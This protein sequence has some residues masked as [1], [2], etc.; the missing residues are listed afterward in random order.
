LSSEGVTSLFIDA[1]N[2]LWI[3]T[4]SGLNVKAPN[5]TTFKRFMND[6]QDASSISDNYILC[7]F[8]DSHGRIWIG[9][10]GHGLN[11][12]SKNWE[13]FMHIGTA[14]GL[15][16]NSIYGI[17][18]DK[19]GYL[20]I[21]TENGLTKLNPADF[22]VQNYNR[23]D[24]LVCKEFNANSY[25]QDTFGNLYF[26]GYNGVVVFN[27]E[28]ISKN[29]TVP[30]LSFVNLRLFNDDVA[31]NQNGGILKQD[32]NYTND[33]TFEYDQNVFA[34]EFAVLNYINSSKNKF[35]YKLIG[36]E[37]QWNISDKPVA[38]YMNLSPGTYTLQVKGSNNDGLWNETPISLKLNILPPLWKTWW[39]YS[40][41][42][43]I[44]LGLLYAWAR[45]S[46]RRMKLE[47]DLELEHLESKKQEELHQA[48][49]SFFANIVHEIRTPLT[50][51]TSP[52]DKLLAHYPGDAFLK[53][54]LSLVKSNTSRLQRLLHQLLD[55]HK[56]ET[57]N[58][59]IRVQEENVI[60]FINEI[61]LSFREYAQARK[62]SLEFYAQQ[63]VIKLW[64]DR[65]EM[66]KVFCNLLLN[67]FKFTP[68]GGKISIGVWKEN[69]TNEA[70]NFD[71]RIAIEDTGLGI[72]ETHLKKI[73]HRFYQAENS[74]INEAG[75]GIGLALTKGIVDLHH[76]SITVESVE[77]TPDQNGFTKFIIVLP[78]GRAHF[79]DEQISRA[80]YED[81]Q[82]HYAEISHD[83]SLQEIDIERN[84][85]HDKP[86]ALVV[87][88]HD[89]IRSYLRDTFLSHY[90]V[91]EARNGLEG[92]TIALEQL[93]DIIISD[94]M[95]PKMN[96]LELVN[97]LKADARTSH[98][99]VILLT[100]RGALNYQVEGFETGADDYLTKPFNIQLLLVKMRSH[101]QV[102]E[103]LK[104]KYSRMVT[105]QPQ[106]EQVQDPDEKFLQ[107]L[108]AILEENI[109]DAE[110][111]VSRLVREI[112]MSRPVLFRKTKMLT[113]LSVIDLIRDLRLKKAA[114]LLKQ[115]KLSISEVAFTVGFSDPKYFSKSFRSH[116]GKSPSQFL[117]DQE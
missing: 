94:V 87:E 58:V 20:W 105:L 33:L 34:V 103:K 93:P 44:F 101:L 17:Q 11:L 115:R 42:I 49:L 67:A 24:G 8:Q 53:K 99:P 86:L 63:P 38:M 54:E 59:Q 30:N 113:G 89:E 18:E 80:R 104:E 112:G 48:K 19:K 9:T 116:F 45:I 117:E 56:Q 100:A 39:A 41:Y 106:Q 12:I 114:M 52:V 3:G 81:D 88:D 61:Q 64:F 85:Q 110:F 47:H 72:S 13:T 60:E 31:V 98:I 78:S 55:F 43:S 76:G 109:T 5:A 6:P 62:V 96:G 22:S 68:G 97:K 75:V 90:Q 25:C 71:V 51:M 36:F 102:R 26:G 108:M 57:G 37:D 92:L 107:R 21:S 1:H 4:M 27:P 7:T 46:R 73:F 65:E 74:G 10:R 32:L 2:N 70:G 29:V 35:A 66:S 82:H 95:M 40:I 83:T 28:T 84:Q 23:S 79:A 111:N 14:E 77:A 50:L 69:R 16:G 91:L 15:A